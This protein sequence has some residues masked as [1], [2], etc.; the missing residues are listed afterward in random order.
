MECEGESLELP[1][2]WSIVDGDDG[3][4]FYY[5]EET[6]RRRATQ[7]SN[8]K[9]AFEKT[10]QQCRRQ[11]TRGLGAV[12]A[13]SLVEQVVKRKTPAFAQIIELPRSIPSRDLL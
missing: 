6:G 11:R 4:T 9:K 3:A 5:N 13:I 2:P 12:G 7:K 10:V 1:Y 8:K